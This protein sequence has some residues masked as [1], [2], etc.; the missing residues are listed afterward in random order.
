[1][2]LKYQSEDQSH[3]GPRKGIIELGLEDLAS[4]AKQPAWL[5][6]PGLESA[7]NGRVEADRRVSHGMWNMAHI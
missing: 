1:M 3:H 7:I 2:D 4:P 6:Y 5:S